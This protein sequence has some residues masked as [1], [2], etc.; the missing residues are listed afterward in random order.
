[1]ELLKSITASVLR[2]VLFGVGVILVEQGWV[3]S[4]DWALLLGGL[5]T[6]A[7]AVVWGIIQKLRARTD[8]G[9][10]LTLPAGST[11]EDV[12]AFT[13]RGGSKRVWSI[14]IPF[15]VISTAL[16]ASAC[17]DDQKFRAED[18]MRKIY[19]GLQG[20]SSGIDEIHKAGKISNDSALAGYKALGQV[21]TSVSLFKDRVRSLDQITVEN[22][23]QLI[24]LLD[25][26]VSDIDKA[27]Q[28]GLIN[29]PRDQVAAIEI[30]YEM[31]KSGAI[32]LKAVVQAV[33]K[34][35][36]VDAIPAFAN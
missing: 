23:V 15:L 4:E 20:A 22:K 33:K 5:I 2:K 32:T 34:P 16:M 14:L 21:G 6:G 27:R 29:I 25:S 18:A 17:N 9:I 31:A 7:S 8:I 30:Y 11:P 12:K 36:K 13:S 24:P 1:M 35:V 19:I 26:L 28:A 3:S 10:A